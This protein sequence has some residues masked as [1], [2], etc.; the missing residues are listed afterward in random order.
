MSDNVCITVALINGMLEGADGK[1]DVRFLVTHANLSPD[2]I[3]ALDFID[4]CQQS[5]RF[6]AK[7]HTCMGNDLPE[8][9]SRYARWLQWNSSFDFRSFLLVIPP[10]L[11]QEKK[12]KT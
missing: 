4:L 12:K 10:V 11:Y 6:P 7:H 3:Q 1:S 9:N 5:A 8:M 2:A